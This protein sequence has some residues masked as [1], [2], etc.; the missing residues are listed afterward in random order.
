MSNTHV[1]VQTCKVMSISNVIFLPRNSVV[2]LTDRAR[3]IYQT[4]HVAMQCPVYLFSF[5]LPIWNNE[6]YVWILMSVGQTAE[7]NLCVHIVLY[8]DTAI[9]SIHTVDMRSKT[10]D[11]LDFNYCYNTCEWIVWCLIY[12]FLHVSCFFYFFF[13]NVDLSTHECTSLNVNATGDEI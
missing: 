10:F 1:H 2:R 7:S 4:A 5:T 8:N 9:V 6:I 12:S 11:R 13:S 3:N